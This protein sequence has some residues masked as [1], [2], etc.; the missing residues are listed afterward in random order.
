MDGIIDRIEKGIAVV[1]TE[2]GMIHCPA[3]SFA[4]EGDCV[5]IEHGHI[6]SVDREKT[7]ARREKVRIRLARMLNPDHS[8]E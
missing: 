4:A 8:P 1:E 3:V 5:V 6:R 2:C 7:Q